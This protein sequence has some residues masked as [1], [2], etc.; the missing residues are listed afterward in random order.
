MRAHDN[1]SLY[2]VSISE[3]DVYDFKQHWPCNGMPDEKLWVQFDKRNGDLV[4][5]V[6]SNWEERGADGSA[7]LALIQDAQ[8]YAVSKLFKQ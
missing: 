5:M 4:D 1:G 6:P 3:V 8:D 7:M 2:S